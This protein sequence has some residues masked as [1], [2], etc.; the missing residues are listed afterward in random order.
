[1]KVPS[2]PRPSR[3]GYWQRAVFA[4]ERD[5]QTPRIDFRSFAERR[6]STHRD[7]THD[8]VELGYIGFLRTAI[9]IY[10]SEIRHI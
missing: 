6:L 8:T 1:M 9:F 5:G 7:T 10:G 4:T 2:D 3:G